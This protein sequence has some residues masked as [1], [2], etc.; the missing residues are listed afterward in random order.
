M[1]KKPVTDPHKA[2]NIQHYKR[3]EKYNK[4]IEKLLND[5]IGQAALIVGRH[6]GKAT[7]DHIFSFSDNRQMK[8]EADKLMRELAEEI[9]QYTKGAETKEWETAYKQATDYIAE[10]YNIVEQTQQRQDLFLDRLLTMK[11]RNM[12]ALESFQKR[13]IGGLKLSSKVWDYTKDFEKQME[14]A[15]DTALLEG[16]SAEALSRD[17]RSLLKD[18]DALFRRV[19]GENDQLR[20][21]KAMEAFHPGPGKYRSAYKN[22]MRLARS[23]INMAYRSSDCDTAQSMDCVVGIRVNL[24]N[25]HT[26]NG[27]PFVDICDE[28]SDQDYPKD[29]IFRGWHP[30][31][32]CF[33]TYITKT[34]E[35]FWRDLEDGVNRRSVNTVDDV[36]DAFKEWVG[37][38]EERIARAEERGTLPYFL[39]DNENYL[40]ST[41]QVSDES[42][43]L[44]DA[45]IGLRGVEIPDRMWYTSDKSYLD[46]WTD[47]AIKVYG[48]DSNEGRIALNIQSKKLSQSDISAAIGIYEYKISKYMEYQ[49]LDNITRLTSFDVS[50][51]PQQWRK[52]YENEITE[53]NKLSSLIKTEGYS[54]FEKAASK[55]LLRLDNMIRLCTNQDAIDYGLSKLS[56][57]TPA[58]FFEEKL[59]DKGLILPSKEFFDSL[60]DYVPL[61]TTIAGTSKHTDGTVYID[62]RESAEI[63]YNKSKWESRTVFEHEYTHANDYLQGWHKDKY[64]VDWWNAFEKKINETDYGDKLKTFIITKQTEPLTGDQKEQLVTLSDIYQAASKDHVRLYGGHEDGYFDKPFK[65]RKEFIAE[66]GETYWSGSPLIEEFDKEFY[67]EMIDI[68]K[69]LLSK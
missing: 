38:N 25:N 32:R 51:L 57:K 42:P 55:S 16:K 61:K 30:M 12:D 41:R 58:T 69:M 62:I 59:S 10:L 17:I 44:D 53:I 36:P 13:K 5:A 43:K 19:R 2:W 47:F 54:G 48:E 68:M 3:L 35:E 23:E 6:D 33:I 28:L 26:C 21:S 1:P 31:C 63:R 18:P 24:S 27:K 49:T 45:I 20:M 56:W 22:A 46:A 15:I 8:A 39:R 7:E 66:C 34:D 60:K 52:V 9:T 65:R 50:K 4:R 14:T 67:G 29:F 64:I 37:N 11:S 40:E